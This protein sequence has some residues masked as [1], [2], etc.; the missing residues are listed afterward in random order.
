MEPNIVK[1][2]KN[3]TFGKHISQVV[4]LLKTKLRSLVKIISLSRLENDLLVLNPV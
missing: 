3:L 4:K 1:D 2:V